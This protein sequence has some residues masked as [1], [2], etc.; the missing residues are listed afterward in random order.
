MLLRSD[1]GTGLWDENGIV[2][3][4]WFGMAWMDG[5]AWRSGDE[6]QKQIPQISENEGWHHLVLRHG[7]GLMYHTRR[8]RCYVKS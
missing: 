4:S 5:I 6:M 1:G 7:D 3:R 2:R 8:L